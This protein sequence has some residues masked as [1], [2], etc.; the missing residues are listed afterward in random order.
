MMKTQYDNM[1]REQLIEELVKTKQEAEAMERQVRLTLLRRQVTPHFLFNSISVAMSLVLQQ[2][3]TAITFLHHLASMYRYLLQYGNNFHVPIEQELVMMQQY[4]ELMSLRHVGTVHLAISPE[5]KACKHYPLPPLAL[6]GLVENA[7]KHNAHTQEQPLEISLSIEDNCL[8]VRNNIVP[9]ASEASTTRMGLA[10]MN[11][12][13]Q[14]LFGKEIRT[15]ND[16]K[17]FTV[18]VPLIN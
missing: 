12:T 8:C 13:M 2:P 16:G 4:Y 7:I 18:M 9:L 6:Q 10:Y 14:L 11:E 17:T 15:V 1:S 3:Q 5:V